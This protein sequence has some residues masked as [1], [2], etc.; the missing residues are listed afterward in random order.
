MLCYMCY[1]LIDLTPTIMKIVGWEFWHFK[2]CYI[3]LQSLEVIVTEMRWYDN[4]GY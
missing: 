1:G 3:L 4:S 2:N